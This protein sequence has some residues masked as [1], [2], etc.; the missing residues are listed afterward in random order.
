[1]QTALIIGLAL[2][3]VG[4]CVL[5]ALWFK[6]KGEIAAARSSRAPIEAERDR[7]SALA[8]ELEAKLDQRDRD[9]D[10]LSVENAVLQTKLEEQASAHSQQLE[11]L[12]LAQRT[13]SEELEK[14]LAEV[15]QRFGKVME[16]TSNEALER[17]TKQ[18][19]AL[20]N[21]TFEKREQASTASLKSLVNPITDT[22]KRTDERIAGIEK[23]R[24]EAHAA[25]LTQIGTMHEN[26]AQLRGETAKLTQALRRP[27]VRGR[28]G[29]VQLERV[30]EL[31]G[32][33]SYCDFSTQ[34][35]VRNDDGE[36]LRPDM[37]VSLPNNR[38]IVIDAKT[39]IDAYLDAI[40]AESDD[41]RDRQLDRFARHVADQAKALSKKGYWS[42]YQGSPDFTVMF[43][44]GDQFIDAALSRRPDLLDAAAQ[45]GVI[46]ASPSTLI[47]LLRAV[48][49]GW[50][51][52]AL[53]DSAQELF[54]LGKELHER[55]STVLDYTA[56]LGT[57]LR[58][59]NNTYN[60]LVGSIDGRLMPSLRKFEDAGAK[61]SKTLET[62]TPVDS[63]PRELKALPTLSD[64][65]V[66]SAD[67]SSASSSSSSG[68]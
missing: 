16:A 48:A 27:E 22:L 41:E 14:R 10:A 52:K 35:S 49:V 40:Q 61:S 19:L 54:A 55:A 37:V 43:I 47:G 51:E 1:M 63:V 33:T 38:Q 17:S 30:A 36:L 28:Y 68:S 5:T 57:H 18:L 59:A 67:P 20:A 56:K 66:G 23:L 3:A 11:A 26:A 29:E 25:L 9:A 24:T 39:N 6:A 65:A 4:C 21:E 15:Q 7:L 58:T 60:S 8:S 45:D 50:R 32:M 42:Q 53:S 12:R 2:F 44:P 64:Q 34:T 31:A 46:L 62:P 13:A